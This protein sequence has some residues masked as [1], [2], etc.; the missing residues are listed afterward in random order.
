MLQSSFQESHLAGRLTWAIACKNEKT[1]LNP[2]HTKKGDR[3]NIP[4]PQF[5]QSATKTAGDPVL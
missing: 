1:I 5:N 2:D 3:T 4:S